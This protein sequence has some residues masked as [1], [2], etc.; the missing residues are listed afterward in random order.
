M[1]GSVAGGSRG[2]TLI[3]L[4]IDVSIDV[5]LELRGGG[6]D[7]IGGLGGAGGA[8]GFGGVALIGGSIFDDTGDAGSGGI[9][10]RG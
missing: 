7:A 1:E 2:A 8:G 10:N 9:G 4:V 3:E 6:A 5:A